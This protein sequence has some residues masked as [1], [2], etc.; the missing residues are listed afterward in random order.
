M[1]PGFEARPRLAL[2]LSCSSAAKM[3]FVQFRS[4]VRGG[5]MS[6]KMWNPQI[7]EQLLTKQENGNPEDSFAV[8]VIKDDTTCAQGIIS[9]IIQRGGYI[10]CE[11]SGR[12]Q[13]S[14]LLQGGLEIPCIYTFKAK[15]KM[16]DKLSDLLLVLVDSD[17]P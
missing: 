11:I 9:N 12:R 5:S 17:G 14:V 8:G 13:C 10:S 6:T 7:G 2:Q 4:C 16:V 15:K 1:W 3:S